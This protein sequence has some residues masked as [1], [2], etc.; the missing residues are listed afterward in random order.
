M[1]NTQPPVLPIPTSHT[2]SG[3]LGSPQD[4]P[5]NGRTTRSSLDQSFATLK[6]SPLHRNSAKGVLGGVCAGIADTTGLSVTAVRAAAIFLALFFGAGVGAYLLGWALLP[7]EAGRTH[8]EQAMRDGRPRS[9]VV[10]G[11]GAIALL[12][13]LSWVFESWGLL[14]AAA[15]V[16]FVVA[17]KK[18]HF[19]GHAHG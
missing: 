9:M 16:A 3:P 10:L 12:G 15:V 1:N 7:D 17:K 6:R 18:G 4:D 13:V 11:L 19:S 14:I 5:P 8:A 2:I